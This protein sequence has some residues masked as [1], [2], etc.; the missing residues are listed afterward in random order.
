M[1]RTAMKPKV[2]AKR[3]P[4]VDK[5]FTILELLAGT[6]IPLGVSD[7]ANRLEYHKSTV[8]NMVYTLI[9]LGILEMGPE[10]KVRL[11]IRLYT[12][13]REAGAVSLLVAK[14]RPFIEEINQRTRLS[15][16]LGIRSD[17]KAVIVDKVDS[18]YDIKVSSEMGMKIPLIAGAGGRALLA[19]LPE[20]QL[21]KILSASKLK[22]FTP[23]T[24]TNLTQFKNNIKNTRK[25]GFALDDEEYIEGLRAL[26]IP[27]KV[28]MPEFQAAIWVV[29]LKSQITDEKISE[30][31][32]LL[33]GIGDRIETLFM[34]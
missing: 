19:Q 10:N 12:L 26:A 18:P 23:F 20:A 15:V 4:A 7:I 27:L 6:P 29:G 32:D 3:V 5:C 34:G 31:K 28:G 24:C 9:D 17:L 11:G 2:K 33:K 25:S 21:L 30:Y 16:F 22:A 13:G 8:F 14:V 1:V